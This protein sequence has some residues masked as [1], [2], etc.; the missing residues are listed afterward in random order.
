MTI[1]TNF[2]KSKVEPTQTKTLPPSSIHL[3]GSWLRV[4]LAKDGYQADVQFI[5]EVNPAQ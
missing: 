3:A 4:N 1:T 5:I 2:A